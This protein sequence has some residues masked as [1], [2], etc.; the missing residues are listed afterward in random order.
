VVESGFGWE[1]VTLTGAGQA[2][3]HATAAVHAIIRFD[4]Q[5]LVMLPVCVPY[6]KQ[7]GKGRRSN[8]VV[9]SR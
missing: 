7:V 8:L 9:S 2:A 1:H 6:N 3:V 4:E 5:K